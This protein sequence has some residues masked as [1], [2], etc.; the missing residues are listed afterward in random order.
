MTEAPSDHRVH[1]HAGGEGTKP[2]SELFPSYLEQLLV[3]YLQY[4]SLI[5]KSS[6]GPELL[7]GTMISYSTVQVILCRYSTV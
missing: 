4:C 5:E 6:S 1:H 2:S 3:C 7:G